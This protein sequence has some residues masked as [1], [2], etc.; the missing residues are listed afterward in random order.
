[1]RPGYLVDPQDSLAVL[2]GSTIDDPLL[3]HTFPAAYQL[4]EVKQEP[5][6]YSEQFIHHSLHDYPTYTSNTT[7]YATMMPMTTVSSTQ[8]LV[9]STSSSKF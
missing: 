6:D 7:N 8:S 5:F 1:M 4:N 9:T 2:L 3:R